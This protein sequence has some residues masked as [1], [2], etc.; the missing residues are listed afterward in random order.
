MTTNTNCARQISSTHKLHDYLAWDAKEWFPLNLL[1]I[2][3]SGSVDSGRKNETI[4]ISI[5]HEWTICWTIHICEHSLWKEKIMISNKL[6]NIK[7]QWNRKKK[8]SFYLIFRNCSFQNSA[9]FDDS[10]VDHAF[11]CAQMSLSCFR[12]NSCIPFNYYQNLF[13]SPW[14]CIIY[15]WVECSKS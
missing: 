2:I 5:G 8:K 15:K 14:I 12:L 10:I 1:V 3:K 11:H 9:H 13:L 6:L 7:F 4:S